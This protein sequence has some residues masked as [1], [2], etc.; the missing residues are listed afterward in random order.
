MCYIHTFEFLFNGQTHIIEVLGYDDEAWDSAIF[1]V[2]EDFNINDEKLIESCLTL[3][4][5]EY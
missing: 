1:Q 4:K 2:K 3:I 5:T